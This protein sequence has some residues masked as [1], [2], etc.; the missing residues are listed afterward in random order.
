M[1]N[2]LNKSQ[3]F[4]IFSPAVYWPHSSIQSLLSALLALPAL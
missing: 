1:R 2:E 3:H 4:E